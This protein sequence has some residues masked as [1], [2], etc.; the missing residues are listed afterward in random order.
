M[1]GLDRHGILASGTNEQVE[2]EIKRAIAGAPRQFMLGADCTV[3]GELS[4]DRLRHAIAV[5]HRTGKG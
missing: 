5:A 1:G 2:A 4:W 3:A